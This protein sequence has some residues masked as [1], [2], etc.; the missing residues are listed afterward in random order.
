MNDPTLIGPCA[1]YEHDLVDLSDGALEPARE[2]A[3]RQHL[4]SCARCSAWQASFAAID[5]R[6]SAALPRVELSAGFEARLEQRLETL[7]RPAVN[8]SLRSRL[9]QE[10]DSLVAALRRG[11]RRQAL[12]GGAASVAVALCIVFAAQDLLARGAELVPGMARGP[13]QLVALGAFGGAI[14]LAALAWSA[15]RMRLRLPGFGR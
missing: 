15:S 14:A 5:A 9:E 10:H 3:V 8:G 12:L 6:L 13:E 4:A 2:Q 7:A 1:E 11:A